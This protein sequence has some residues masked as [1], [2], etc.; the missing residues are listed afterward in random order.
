MIS[1]KRAAMFI[2]FNS[3]ARGT[4]V[5]RAHAG[6]MPL[7]VTL[8]SPGEDTLSSG[9]AV[10]E[11]PRRSARQCDPGVRMDPRSLSTLSAS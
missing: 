7:R 11:R 5:Q 4:A 9:Y 1:G 3:G 10:E 2:V 8:R 6:D